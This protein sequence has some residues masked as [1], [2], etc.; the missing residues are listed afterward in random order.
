MLINVKMPTIVGILTLMSMMDF[1]SVE[2][3]V[4]KSCI[5]PEP[6]FVL[7]EILKTCKTERHNQR[8]IPNLI[9]NSR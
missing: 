5:T 7:L 1:F 9:L 3:S 8:S 2:M 4:K 6:V